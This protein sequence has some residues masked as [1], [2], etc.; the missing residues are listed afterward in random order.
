[1]RRQFG[2]LLLLSLTLGL[3]GCAPMLER[4]SLDRPLSQLPY[5]TPAERAST[6]YRIE[7]A[8]DLRPEKVSKEGE[9]HERRFINRYGALARKFTG[10]EAARPA[11]NLWRKLTREHEQRYP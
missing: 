6:L 3:T 2:L 9:R 5:S 7:A 11:A 1:M 10:T 4:S 8:W